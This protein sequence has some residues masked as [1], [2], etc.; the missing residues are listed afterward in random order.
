LS[1][2][3]NPYQQLNFSVEN[4]KAL[5]NIT[6]RQTMAISQALA[7]LIKPGDTLLLFGDVGSGKTFF[8]R[9]VIQTMMQKQGVAIEDVPSPTFTIV[10]VYDTIS[11][12]V[13]HLDLYRLSSSEEI[14]D[15]DIETA[16]EKSVCLIEWPEKMTPYLP[17][18]Y[19]SIVFQQTEGTCDTRDIT[20]EFNGSGWEHIINEL[21][22]MSEFIND[23]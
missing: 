13:W 9:L 19:L 3:K 7:E 12:A 10:Q 14:I 17:Q 22:Q 23:F 21:S 20:F 11:P 18:R 15:L 5:Y 4:K 1:Q 2:E 16:L 6:I 8:S